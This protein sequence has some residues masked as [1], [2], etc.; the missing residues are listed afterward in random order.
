MTR[1][2][3]T[4]SRGDAR[5]T[6]YAYDASGRLETVASDGNLD[7]YGYDESG[8]LMTVTRGDGGVLVTARFDDR[9]RL[10]AHGDRSFRYSADGTLLEVDGPDGTT[11]F[12]VDDLGALRSVLLAEGRRIDY[13][14]DA[15]GRRIG[16]MVDGVL[17]D[18]YLYSVDDSIVAWTDGSGQMI[19]RFAYDDLAGSRSYGATGRNWPWSPTKSARP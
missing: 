18:G 8:N 12:D 2:E 7:T 4:D 3:R 16:R 5:A 17:T 19:A 9:D 6:D 15:G 13:V 11:T 1:V 14:I 10:L